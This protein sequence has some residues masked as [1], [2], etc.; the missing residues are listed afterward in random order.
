VTFFFSSADDIVSWV[1]WY[2]QHYN[3]FAFQPMAT[4]VPPHIWK[5]TDAIAYG[6]KTQ[7][8]QHSHFRPAVVQITQQNGWLTVTGNGSAINDQAASIQK[9]AS[10]HRY[11]KNL[12]AS[13]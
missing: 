6:L 7:L 5:K 9:T 10:S 12:D 2:L 11:K 4:I 13:L 1:Y 3:T 8:C